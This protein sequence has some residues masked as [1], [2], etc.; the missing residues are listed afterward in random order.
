M[1]DSWRFRVESGREEEQAVGGDLPLPKVVANHSQGEQGP[2]GGEELG[3][4]GNHL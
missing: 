4:Q 1:K 2:D 3:E